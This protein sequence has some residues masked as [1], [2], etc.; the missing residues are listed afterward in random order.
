MEN[1]ILVSHPEASGP[2]DCLILLTTDDVVRL[3]GEI[4]RESGI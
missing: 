4:G 3:S 2:A 1:A